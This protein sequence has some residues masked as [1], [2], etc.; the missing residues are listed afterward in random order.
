MSFNQ[1]LYPCD[2][3]DDQFE[4]IS[5]L[6]PQAKS[7]G[8]PRTVD[9]RAVLNAIFYVLCTGCPWRWLPREYP[10]KGTV[11]HYFRS[12]KLDGTWLKIHQQLRDWLRASYDRDPSQA[13]GNYRFSIRCHRNHGQQRSRF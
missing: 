10:P 6:I 3:T 13:C 4:L 7:G 8:R 2:L 1:Q 9:I 12:W 11:Y 5:H